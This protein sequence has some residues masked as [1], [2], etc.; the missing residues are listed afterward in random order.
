MTNETTNNNNNEPIA[1]LVPGTV[2][3]NKYELVKQV[4]NDAMGAVWKAKDRV[5]DRT[6]ALKFV[7]NELRQNESEMNQIR[8]MFKRVH[9]L[10]HPSICALYG[11]ENG[12]H[13]GY[14]IV[15]R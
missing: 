4:S 8:E 11:Q 7:P 6:V 10:Q 15:M 12:G 13:L 2:L 9:A 3:N 5:A 1:S 14:Y